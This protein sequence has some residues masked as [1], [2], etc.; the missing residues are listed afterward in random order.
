MLAQRKSPTLDL[1]ETARLLGVEAERLVGG[2]NLVVASRLLGI[3]PSTL[4]QRA[5]RS[6]IGYQRDG[7][8]WRFF[9]WHLA[10]Y[11]ERR[12]CLTTASGEASEAG[13]IP[14]GTT[15]D[16]EVIAAAAKLGL[17]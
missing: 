12:E 3:S 13:P 5:L 6:R 14:R 2:L 1:N 17:I 7:R 9:W 11:I 16:R 4:R 10:E 15:E 8:A